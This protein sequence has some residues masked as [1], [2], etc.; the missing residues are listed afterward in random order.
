MLHLG[1]SAGRRHRRR[2]ALRILGGFQGRSPCVVDWRGAGGGMGGLAWRT[3][4]REDRQVGRQA[5][6]QVDAYS[7]TSVQSSLGT[8]VGLILSN[9][10]CCLAPCSP[11]SSSRRAPFRLI[12][13]RPLA[14]PSSCPLNIPSAFHQ[15]SLL[16]SSL[17]QHGQ[18]CQQPRQSGHLGIGLVCTAGMP[19]L[20]S[21][22]LK[23]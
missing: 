4:R 9:S 18:L 23:C 5:S 2:Q 21:L 15:H 1:P 11:E 22:S 14:R 6:G 8:P 3:G 10:E 7:L 16:Y 20:A 13:S 19:L 12:F 17:P